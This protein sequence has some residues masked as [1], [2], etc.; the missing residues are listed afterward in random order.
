MN[1]VAKNRIIFLAFAPV[2]SA[3]I[4]V[5]WD[6]D[7]K[8]RSI[9]CPAAAYQT[10]MTIQISN[11]NDLVYEHAV[12]TTVSATPAYPPAPITLNAVDTARQRG[13]AE[14]YVGHRSSTR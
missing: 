10:R 8:S 12:E 1:P 7:P 13:I 2:L 11:V 4:V 3:Q 6:A 9:N 14:L 5:T